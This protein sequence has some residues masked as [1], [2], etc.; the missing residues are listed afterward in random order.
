MNFGGFLHHDDD[1]SSGGETVGGGNHFSSAADGLVKSVF[2][3]P[4]LSLG[5]QTNGENNGGGG[6]VGRIGESLEVSV[7]RTSPE[8]R[9]GSDNAEA[10][11]GDDDV[12]ASDHR[13]F[14]KKK[15]YHR[16]TPQQIHELESVFKECPHPDEKQ[17][18]DLSHRLNL[19]SRQVKFWFQNRRTQMKT[20]IERHENALLRQEN[21]KLRAE[22]MSVREAMR[23]PMCGHCGGSAVLAEISL[24]EHHLRIENSRLKDEL[25]RICALAGKFINRS[26]D[27]LPNSALRLVVGSK[28][29]YGGGDGFTL[30]P[31]PGFEMSSSSP[32][33]S[34]LAAPVNRSGTDVATRL[35]QKSLYMELALSAMEELVEMAQTS[36]PL[37][38]PSSKGKRESLNREEYDKKFS[39]CSVGPKPDGFVSEA[40]KEVGMVI[41]NSLA[42]V[43]TLMDSERWAEMFPCMIARNSTTEII[44]NGMGGTRNGALHLM[45]AELQ[46][47]S[48][49]VPVRQVNFLRFCKQHA[50]GVW[51]VVDVSDD[52]ISDRGGSASGRSSLS[53]RRLPSGCLVQDM[54]N[55][56]S[57]ITWIDHS[58]YDE[59]KIHHLYRPLVSSGLA[60]GSKR[61]ISTLQRQCESLTILMSS[62]IPNRNIKPTP[63]SST[64]KKSML[65]LAQR[66]TE[67][68]CRGVCA[69]SSQKW[70]RLEVG[71]IDEDVRIMTRKNED[72]S[73]EPPGILLSAATSVW[74]PVSPRRLFDFL[75][76]ELLRSDWD[77]LSNGGP[78]QEIA[79]IFKGQDHSNS[80]S[81]LRSTAMNANQSCMLI[82]QE[83]SI[84]ASGAFVVYAPV[85][86]PAMHS[87]MN[88][89]DSAYVALLPSGFAILPNGQGM[90]ENESL[91]TVAFQILVN[92]LPTAKLNVESIETVNNLIS[93]TVHKIRAAL[94]CDK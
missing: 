44:S 4:R 76:D 93:C 82:L 16:H 69:S 84:D 91:L 55:G 31:P 70:S 17:R 39:S 73:G 89:A 13:P 62:T 8:S 10:L 52:K 7:S 37:W 3:S 30:V 72:D 43:E 29:G 42:L 64:G 56:Y 57:K 94:R 34:G 28:N 45:Q 85:D 81:L 80:V 2:S 40:S 15:R 19:D 53:C 67:N 78:M 35:Q 74:V 11:S 54:P 38:I 48:P 90:P 25:D 32:F 59:T 66:M 68:F 47:L 77:I 33:F 26:D 75:R 23:N 14:K 12:D 1:K 20:Q 46:L 83:T 21:D 51:A 27:Q 9:S 18:L 5:L 63:I 22:N 36:E 65:K 24:E 6:E 71:N 87:V 92:S 61:W 50:E 79:N 60:F 49:L 58:E 88:G 86:I 41:I